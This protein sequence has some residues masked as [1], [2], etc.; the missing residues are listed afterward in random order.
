MVRNPSRVSLPR[1]PSSLAE[2]A[3]QILLDQLLTKKLMPGILINRRAIA[4][5]LGMSVAPVLEAIIQL[6]SEGFLKSIPRKGTLVCA[7]HLEGFRGQL[8]LR[9]AI[10]CEAAR[11]Y[12][13]K[14]VIEAAHLAALAVA[15][16]VSQQKPLVELWKAELAFHTALIALTQCD[17]LIQTYAKTMQRKLFSSAH[18]FLG[19]EAFGGGDHAALLCG[20]QTTDPDGAERLIRAHLHF[21]K[22][23]LFEPLR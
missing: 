20:L 2:E 14:P 1:K 4:T 21:K 3:Y 23:R 13:G 18:L 12:C 8:L 11:L 6:Q 16:D 19:G 5:D 15:A 7:V 9:E 10:E 22:E 17:T